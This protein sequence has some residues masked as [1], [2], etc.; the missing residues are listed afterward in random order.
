MGIP[1]VLSRT[2]VAHGAH[3][4]P[5]YFGEMGAQALK[6]EGIAQAE[7]RR[8]LA[9]SRLSGGRERALLRLPLNEGL[10]MPQE[11]KPGAWWTR[12]INGSWPTSRKHE[13]PVGGWMKRGSR[14]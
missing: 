9:V 5:L 8:R 2:E 11:M 6:L 1:G 7:A 13:A 10:A 4:G 12:T 14:W 3:Y